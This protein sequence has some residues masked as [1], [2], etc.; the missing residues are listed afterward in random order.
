MNNSTFAGSDRN[1][2]NPTADDMTVSSGLLYISLKRI[3]K[4]RKLK[5]SVFF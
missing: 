5:P 3:S 2:M 1:Q 4:E